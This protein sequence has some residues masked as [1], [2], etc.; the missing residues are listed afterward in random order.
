MARSSSLG[1]IF[2]L[3]SSSTARNTFS[4]SVSIVSDGDVS[5][6]AFS[7]SLFRRKSFIPSAFD[8]SAT[9]IVPSRSTSTLAKSVNHFSWKSCIFSPIR[10]ASSGSSKPK[11]PPLSSAS[12]LA[13]SAAP[14]SMCSRVDAS[15]CVGV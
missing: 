7:M 1:S 14:L 8:S 15:V 13:R 3:P 10:R 6:F 12:I 9:L 4:A 2:P 11:Y 5:I